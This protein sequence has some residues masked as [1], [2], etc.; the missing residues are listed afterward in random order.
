M[1]T[2]KIDYKI[3]R[4]ALNGENSDMKKVLIL[5]ALLFIQFN[6]LALNAD[7]GIQYKLNNDLWVTF[8]H[9]FLK[10]M[11][12][13]KVII[14]LRAGSGQF[15][16][17]TADFGTPERLENGKWQITAPVKSGTYFIN[18][19]EKD[20]GKT[21]KLVLF[22]LVPASEI[23]GEYLN[24]YRIGKYPENGYNNDPAY[25]KPLGFIEV[26][27]KNKNLYISPH[28]QL[29][30]FLCKQKSEWPK[31]LI[32]DPNLLAKLEFLLAELNK[33]GRNIKTLFIMSGFRTPYY[34][35]KIGNVKYSRHVYGNAADVYVDTNG[36]GVID[37]LNH[38]GKNNMDDELVLYKIVNSFDADPDLSKLIGGI[39][40]YKKNSRHTFFIHID[41][42]GYKARW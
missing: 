19:E 33:S 17:G 38:D 20:T 7:K 4:F 9:F 25:N 36:D 10:A 2:Y 11:P 37:D 3:H 1:L 39:G 28:F 18:F 32:V 24:R 30:Q 27:A 35:K 42:R 13:E 41:T 14:E 5:L 23:D 21:L 34:N 29:K 8:N 16:L 26:T 15:I 31:Y 40:K 6:L 22:V 12:G